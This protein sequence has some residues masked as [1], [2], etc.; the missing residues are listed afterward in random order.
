M[1]R[2]KHDVKRLQGGHD[3]FFFGGIFCVYL[4]ERKED[5]KRFARLLLAVV[6]RVLPLRGYVPRK[7]R[8][9]RQEADEWNV[10]AALRRRRFMSMWA[11]RTRVA[12]Y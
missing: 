12:C 9:D 6:D 11:P 5:G 4:G 7:R 10:G 3:C 1:A 2:P 8:R